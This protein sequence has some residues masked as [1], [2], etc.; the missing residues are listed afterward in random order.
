MSQELYETIHTMVEVGGPIMSRPHP[1][2]N[3]QGVLRGPLANLPPNFNA[4]GSLAAPGLGPQGRL[5][6]SAIFPP[7]IQPDQINMA[8]FFWYLVK[9]TR[10]RIHKSQKHT[11]KFSWSPFSFVNID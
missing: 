11:S 2:A 5:P 7:G 9:S 3:P 6:P 1:P 10:R 8:V 4:P